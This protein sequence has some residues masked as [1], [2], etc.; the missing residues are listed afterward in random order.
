MIPAD[1]PRLLSPN[2]KF[3]RASVT[4]PSKPVFHLEKATKSKICACGPALFLNLTQ[5]IQTKLT[6]HFFE[7]FP[8]AACLN[9]SVYRYMI[10]TKETSHWLSLTGLYSCAFCSLALHNEHLRNSFVQHTHRS[11]NHIH[12]VGLLL[13]QPC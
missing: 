2:R 9:A 11:T 13:S 6:K 3:L 5:S 10:T 1:W 4:S 7:H 8:Q 12:I